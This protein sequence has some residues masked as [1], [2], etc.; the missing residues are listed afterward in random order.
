MN[1]FWEVVE[2]LLLAI[3]LFGLAFIGWIITPM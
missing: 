2:G 1:K 3:L